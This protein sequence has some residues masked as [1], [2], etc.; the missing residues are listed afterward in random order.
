MDPGLSSKQQTMQERLA[1]DK[2]SSLFGP[3]V[4]YEGRTI[5]GYGL[6]SKFYINYRESSGA[7]TLSITTLSLITLNIMVK[8]HSITIHTSGNT[9]GGSITVPL[10]PCLTGLESAV[11]QLKIFFCI[12]D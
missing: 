5:C 3:F 11:W 6:L 2:H 4:S 8:K 7:T 10:T 1:R 12:A 9:K